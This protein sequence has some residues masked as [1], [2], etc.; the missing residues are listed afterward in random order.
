MDV[1]S[2]AIVSVPV[3]G[4]VSLVPSLAF[5]EGTTVSSSDFTGVISVLQ[6]QISVST[7]V[8]VLTTAATAAVGLAFM[9]WGVRKVTRVLMAAFRTGRV[10]I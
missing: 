4:V 1:K 8:G 9:W 6:G 5:A 3:A 10:S 2:K 7:V